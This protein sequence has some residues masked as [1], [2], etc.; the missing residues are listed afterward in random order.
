MGTLTQTD[1]LGMSHNTMNQNA[2]P[3]RRP[4]TFINL[5]FGGKYG[6]TM[7]KGIYKPP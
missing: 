4:M 1:G 6:I 7:L 2:E 3:M 5:N